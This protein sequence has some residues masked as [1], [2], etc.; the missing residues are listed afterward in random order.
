[1][2]ARRQKKRISA[3][4]REKFLD[5]L[6]RGLTVKAAAEAAAH[7]AVTFFA[8]AARDP[9][10]AEQKRLAM[11]V[12]TD[13][14]EEE[15]SRRGRDGWLEPVV[16]KVAPGI[17]GHVVGP[18]GEPMYIRRYSDRLME[19]MLKGRRPE[20]RDNPRIDITN[21]TLNVPFV[22]RSAT[23]R[24][25]AQVFRDLGLEPSSLLAELD[26][27]D[28]PRELMPG[29]IEGEARRLKEGS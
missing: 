27:P 13:L 5:G 2:T 28:P 3:N 6:R 25:V 11:E 24:E 29:Q 15:A 16:G 1:M 9:E 14:L 21:Q 12:G 7:P 26:V 22:D 18:D 20:Y 23:L 4:D 17:D 10:F 8:L 19:V